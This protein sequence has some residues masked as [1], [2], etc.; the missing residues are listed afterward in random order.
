MLSNLEAPLHGLASPRVFLKHSSLPLPF[1][2]GPTPPTRHSATLPGPECF[3]SNQAPLVY[4][5]DS[6]TRL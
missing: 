4:E 2:D 1:S 3:S 5:S 6:P